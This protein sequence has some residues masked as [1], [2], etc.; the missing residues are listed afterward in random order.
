M[1]GKCVSEPV[2]AKTAEHYTWGAACDGWRLA[3]D[4]ALSVIEER[5]PPGTAEQRHFHARARQFFYVL[6]GELEMECEG[7]VLRIGA[8]QG[9]EIAPGQRHQAKNASNAEVRFLVVSTTPSHGDRV[10]S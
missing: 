2:S 9:V 7:A 6:E 8:R 3:Q 10:T 4:D 5:M 1:R